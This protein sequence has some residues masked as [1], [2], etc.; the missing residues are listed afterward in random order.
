MAIPSVPLPCG[1]NANS[2]PCFRAL[3]PESLMD[4]CEMPTDMTMPSCGHKVSVA[5]RKRAA[6]FSDPSRCPAECGAALPCGHACRSLCGDC[7]TVRSG[8]GAKGARPLRTRRVAPAEGE[9][10]GPDA[11]SPAVAAIPGHKPCRSQCGRPLGCG[12][13]CEEWCH[14]S[15]LAG[16]RVGCRP[17]KKKC[18]VRCEHTRCPLGC[19]EPCS[20]CIEPCPWARCRH[21]RG[22][23]GAPCGA[24]CD[25]LPCDEVCG[26]PLACGHPCP[27][28]CGEPCPAPKIACRQCAPAARLEAVVDLVCMATLREHD[29]ARDGPLIALPCG[30]VYAVSTLDAHME[31]GAYYVQGPPPTAQA[32][33]ASEWSSSAWVDCAQLPQQLQAVRGCPDCRAPIVGTRRYGR[34]VNKAI[35]DQ[36]TRK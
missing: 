13:H 11:G 26:R 6:T 18:P 16:A 10:V 17:C 14:T 29:P 1:H 19:A 3:R 24:P 2:V 21:G 23:C 15:P 34:V 4:E 33:G 30:H 28:P 7:F 20:P 31:L 32:G 22:G 9:A 35:L 36:M 27:A 8:A 5:C 25:A 12:H